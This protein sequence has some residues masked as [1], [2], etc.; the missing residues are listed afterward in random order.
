MS[1]KTM[2]LFRFAAAG[3]AAS[4]MWLGSGAANAQGYL[5]ADCG[6]AYYDSE[7]YDYYYGYDYCGSES[8]AAGVTNAADNVA[9]TQQQNMIDRVLRGEHVGGLFAI[10]PT[11]RVQKSKH[12]GFEQ[13]DT[14]FT[15]GETEATEVS[16]FINASYDVPGV[17]MGGKLKLAALFG[18]L[19]LSTDQEARGA[20]FA[21]AQD[22][23]S[24]FFGFSSVWAQG[25]YYSAST[26][27]FFYGDTSGTFFDGAGG[28]GQVNSDTDGYVSNS[29]V[30]YVF[31][32]T[33]WG[34]NVKFDLRG[35]LGHSQG[36]DD[37]T[38]SNDP[39]FNFASR[40][41]DIE[42]W[43]GTISG[44]LFMLIPTEN[45]GISRP[46]VQLSYRHLIDYQNDV[47]I[48]LDAASGGQSFTISFDQARDYGRIDL[49]FDHVSGPY[50]FGA[51]VYVEG[52]Q[53]EGVVGARVGLSYKFQ[54]E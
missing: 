15:T 53:D 10:T 4:A 51:A 17:V 33:G 2:A 43:H 52:S 1:L 37:F 22:N 14:A 31:D 5:N 3:L 19:H 23:E 44:M 8:S 50:T 46:F 18:G 45:G 9:T 12:D 47:D 27:V 21:N 11:G 42:S 25:N 54:Q 24:V 28:T 29:V 40:S 30:G 49:G 48:T 32:L 20:N 36:N 38:G 35:A 34:D 13:V 26:W 39:A 16:A 41:T 6:Y 7:S